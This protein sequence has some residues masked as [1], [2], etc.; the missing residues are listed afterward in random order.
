[1]AGSAVKSLTTE[2]IN[3][4]VQRTGQFFGPL[5]GLVSRCREQGSARSLFELEPTDLALPSTSAAGARALSSRVK[6]P[7]RAAISGSISL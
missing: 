7:A 3:P 2:D 1:M 6:L 5:P 4:R